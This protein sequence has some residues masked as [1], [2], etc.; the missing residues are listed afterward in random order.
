[1]VNATIAFK[2]MTNRM[3]LKNAGL[4]TGSAG[5]LAG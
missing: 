2:K 4:A 3:I 1:M 5:V